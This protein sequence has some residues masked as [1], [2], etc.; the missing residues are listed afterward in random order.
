MDLGR[1]GLFSLL[2]RRLDYLDQRQSVLAENIANADTPDYRAR[3]L[4]PFARYLAGSAPARLELASTQPGHLAGAR[5][6]AAAGVGPAAGVYETTPSGNAVNLEEQ[7]IEMTRNAADHQL[8]L[9]L[10]RK[11]AAMIRS[12][13]GRSG[14]R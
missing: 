8:A 4:Q 7:M 5:G 11:H 9:N 13:L 10:Y 2:A 3:D 1:F 12:A 14:G 6:P